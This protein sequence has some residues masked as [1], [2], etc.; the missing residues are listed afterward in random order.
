MTRGNFAK[1]A[2][3]GALSMGAT[4]AIKEPEIIDESTKRLILKAEAAITESLTALKSMPGSS[5]KFY[6]SSRL[7]DGTVSIGTNIPFADHY[8][9]NRFD[10]YGSP[11]KA[12]S[13]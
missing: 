12:F 1:A 8:E 3:K 13:Y 4:G 2:I 10:E 7:G 11:I 6:P 9:I 5:V